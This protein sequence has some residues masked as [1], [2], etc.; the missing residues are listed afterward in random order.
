MKSKQTGVCKID[1]T[2][3][4]KDILKLIEKA[5]TE[6]EYKDV[7]GFW[8]EGDIHSLSQDIIEIYFEHCRCNKATRG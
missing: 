6:R 8:T 2:E 3:F 1:P 5:E 4:G 7:D